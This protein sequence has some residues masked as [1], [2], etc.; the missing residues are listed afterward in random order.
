MPDIEEITLKQVRFK[1]NINQSLFVELYEG[2][3][4]GAELSRRERIH[5]LSFAILFLRADDQ[6]LGRLGYRILL[7]YS[8]RFDDYEPLYRVALSRNIAPLAALIERLN[9][10]S[11]LADTFGGELMSSHKESFK[12]TSQNG[13]TTYRTKG[14][15]ELRAFT[16]REDSFVVVAPTSYGKSE[17][18]IERVLRSIG[19]RICV[20]VPTKALIAQT[21]RMLMSDDRIRAA[22]IQV[23][24][25]P[26]AFTS[27]DSF[28]AVMTQERLF[29]LMQLQPELMLDDVL[30]DEAHNLMENNERSVHLSQVLLANMHRNNALR[31][32]YYTP[33]LANTD[34]LRLAFAQTATPGKSVNETVKVE[35]LYYTDLQDGQLFMYDQFLDRSFSVATDIPHDEVDVVS[36]FAGRKNIIYVNRPKQA[37][38]IALDMASKFEV[39]NS[40]RLKTAVDAM[41][42]LIH[43][44]YSLLDCIRHGVLFHH[45]SVPEL[46]RD[47]IEDLFRGPGTSA[48]KYMCTTST[49]L[50]GVNTPADTMFILNPKKGLGNLKPSQF[51][52]LVGRVGR[53]GEVFSNDRND[54]ELLQPKIFVLN[55]ESSPSNFNPL[56]F[57]KTNADVASASIDEVLNPLLE[58]TSIPEKREPLVEYLQNMEPGLDLLPEARRAQSE[59][60]QLCFRNGVLDFDIFESEQILQANLARFRTDALL[61]AEADEIVPAIAAIFFEGMSA[62]LDADLARVS[63]NKD[64]QSFYSMF[65]GWR[66]DGT[67]YKQMV[68][69]F[70]RYWKTT[71][72]EMTFVGSAWGDYPWSDS[73]YAKLY[74]RLSE[75]SDQERVNLAVARVKEEQD[76]V[77]FRLMRFAEVM[78]DLG[79]F[80]E[81]LYDRLKFGTD[82][83]DIICMLKNGF[84]YELARLLAKKYRSRID[85]DL[86][87]GTAIVQKNLPKMMRSAMENDILIYEVEC[88]L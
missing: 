75:K 27:L 77:D 18:M 86:D 11:P 71:D 26:D 70:L 15:M 48:P 79:L 30:V 31:I 10:E 53:F 49:L 16:E 55:G 52:N 20:L 21:K 63:D 37:E 23:L 56:T 38:S 8:N 41:A 46:L 64:A 88:H 22:H 76:F 14:Q 5:L 35:R 39:S 17:M 1:P 84:S 69:H 83:P 19:S 12:V 28:V 68:A 85:L 24:T 40:A 44:K 7:Q 9:G 43:P 72:Q 29:R 3:F 13:S 66:C 82:D 54:L 4:T 87:L 59:I 50:E 33:F 36:R 25:H 60:G 78:H 42:K 80:D 32:S 51:K 47:Y 74:V 62:N 81:S 65:V 58:F 57:L 6:L 34:S 2:L 61:I 67:S 73:H 45:G